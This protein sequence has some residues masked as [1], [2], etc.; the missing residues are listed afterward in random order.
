M[1]RCRSA[2]PGL[3]SRRALSGCVR[4]ALACD[5]HVCGDYLRDDLGRRGTEWFAAGRAAS[6]AKHEPRQPWGPSSCGPLPQRLLVG[7]DSLLAL[8]C[9]PGGRARTGRGLARDLPIDPDLRARSRWCDVAYGGCDQPRRFL[10]ARPQRDRRADD[11]AQIHDARIR[12]AV[13]TGRTR[14]SGRRRRTGARRARREDQHDPDG[15]AGGDGTAERS[16]EHAQPL[17]RREIDRP[18]GW[19]GYEARAQACA[20]AASRPHQ[21]A[22]VSERRRISAEARL[23]ATGTT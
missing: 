5:V 9:A 7:D 3:A 17:S 20:D 4:A 2:R 16:L 11:M 21:I 22:C 8:P 18:F 13:R 6:H 23:V 10:V 14:T 1:A 15:S 12:D 19:K